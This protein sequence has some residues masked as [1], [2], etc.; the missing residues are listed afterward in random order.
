MEA[1]RIRVDTNQDVKKIEVNDQGECIT[2]NLGDFSF[3]SRLL[4]LIQEFGASAEKISSKVTE[5]SGTH[6]EQLAELADLNL[7]A[8][9]SIKQRVDDVLGPDTCKKVFGD[10]TP[11]IPDFTDFFSQLMEIVKRFTR[12]QA[13]KRQEAIH[14]YTAKYE[15]GGESGWRRQTAESE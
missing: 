3:L 5:L 6:P 10:C 11:G 1:I 8:C 13:E 2:L 7:S 12:E 14:K 9:N 4:S 15:N